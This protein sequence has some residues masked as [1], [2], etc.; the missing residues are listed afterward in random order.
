ML[1]QGRLKTMFGRYL[2]AK[3]PYCLPFSN[4]EREVN[5]LVGFRRLIRLIEWCY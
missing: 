3:S 5:A 4:L 1:S 2:K